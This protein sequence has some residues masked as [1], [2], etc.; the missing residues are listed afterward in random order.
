MPRKAGQAAKKQFAPGIIFDLDGVLFDSHPV[1]K[2]VW[3]GLLQSLGRS[4][5]EEELDFILDGAKREEILQHFLG[6]L[7]E[8]QASSFAARKESMVRREEDNIHPMKGLETFLDLLDEATISKVVATSASRA[9]AQRMLHNRNLAKRF[10]AVFTGDDVPFGKS[11]PDIFLRSAEVLQS[12]PQETL[13]FEDAV[14]AIRTAKGIGMK[15]VG[16]ARGQRKLCLLEA[17]ADLVVSDFT[18]MSVSVVLSLL[19]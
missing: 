12:S 1:H 4:V 15:C 16:L 18:D 3:R 11:K 17:G 2:R 19:E 13:V 8:A 6:P 5:S 10:A 9:R 14:P 7:S